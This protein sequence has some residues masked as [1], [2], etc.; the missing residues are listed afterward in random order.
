L[1]SLLV[2]QVIGEGERGKV[3][4]AVINLLSSAFLDGP[5]KPTSSCHVQALLC[6]SPGHFRLVA[7]KS[8]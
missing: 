8:F 7:M 5:P 1:F 6:L 4:R 2:A 3:Q